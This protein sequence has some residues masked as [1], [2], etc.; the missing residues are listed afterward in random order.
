L[1]LASAALAI[2]VVYQIDRNQQTKHDLIASG[3]AAI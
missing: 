2:G 1:L 3:S